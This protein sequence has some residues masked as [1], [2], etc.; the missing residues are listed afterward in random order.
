MTVGNLNTLG[1]FTAEKISQLDHEYL[2]YSLMEVIEIGMLLTQLHTPN[3]RFNG[4]MAFG[5]PSGSVKTLHNRD[6]SREGSTALEF[7]YLVFRIPE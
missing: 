2:P 4:T 3:I 1:I 6:Q 5:T 7:L